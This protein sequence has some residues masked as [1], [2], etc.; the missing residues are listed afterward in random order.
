MRVKRNGLLD[1]FGSKSKG[2]SRSEVH[3]SQIEWLAKTLKAKRT[4]ES[5]QGE[6]NKPPY[7][8]ANQIITDAFRRSEEKSLITDAD[9]KTVIDD[10]WDDSNRPKVRANPAKRQVKRNGLLDVFGS[11]SKGPSRSEVHASQVEWLTKTLKSKRDRES[12]KGEWNKPPYWLA[13]QMITDAFRRSEEKSLITDA[14]IKTIIDDL[15]DD[16]HR[17]TEDKRRALS[18]KL[19]KSQQQIHGNPGNRAVKRNG[20]LDV[21]GSKSKGPSRSEVHASQIEW[22]TKTLKA[23]RTRESQQGEWNKPPYWFANQMITDA[24]RRSEEK[25]LITDADIKTVIDDLW[26]DSNRP[27]VRANPSMAKKGQDEARLTA[28][29]IGHKLTPFISGPGNKWISGCEICGKTAIVSSGKLSG[30]AISVSC[31]KRK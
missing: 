18:E 10:L 13:N 22:L 23:K 4:R 29:F 8:F 17:F 14:D 7:W 26:D 31:S 20:L 3:A 27:K 19:T 1:V 9:I 21:F 16:S 24:F 11:K 25:S 15:W 2:P 12:N 5:Q 6:W 30:D 28:S